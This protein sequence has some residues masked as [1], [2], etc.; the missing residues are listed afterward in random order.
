MESVSW[1][2]D[3]EPGD[4]SSVAEI[5]R[6]SFTD[7]WSEDALDAASGS[8]LVAEREGRVVGYVVAVSVID[9]G[10]IMNLAVRPDVR[11]LGLGR[12]LLRSALDRLALRGITE[13]FLEVR[14]SNR[15]ARRLYETEGF[16]VVGSHPGYYS[17]P[18]EDAVVLRR[19]LRAPRGGAK[20]GLKTRI[21]G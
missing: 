17:R 19:R 13:V 9:E 2:R 21:F 4:I 8:M 11:G 5:E 1:I 15:A 12:R 3:A 18:P 10:E 20:K 6:A 7:P 16:R 14:R